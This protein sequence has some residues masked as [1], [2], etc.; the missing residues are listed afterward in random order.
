MK[1]RRSA[2]GG[3]RFAVSGRGL[4][5]GGRRSA[6][7]VRFIGMKFLLLAVLTFSMMST[8]SQSLPVNQKSLLKLAKVMAGEFDSNEQADLDKSY[9]HIVLRMKPIWKD[10][11]D[12]YWFYVEQSVTSSQHQPYRQRVYHLYLH[13]DTTIVSKVYELRN[14][15]QYTG[16]WQNDSL[17]SIIAADSLIDRQGCAIYLH[18]KS[19]KRVYQGSTPGKECLSSL[20]GATYATSEVTIYPDRMI[21][22]DRGWNES[23]Q[24]VW[25]AE[26]GG[27]IF[28]K[29]K[30][31]K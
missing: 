25:G 22:W 4:A 6:V 10:D 15:Q 24:Q 3:Q 23:E 2:V 28:I 29:R 9:Y 20:R 1:G 12:G 5:I 31:F 26:E 19:K 18:K 21:S 7:R 11:P 30:T 14:P 17:L 16:A 13:D 27:Y 8:F